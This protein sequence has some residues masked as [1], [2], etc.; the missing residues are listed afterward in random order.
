LYAGLPP[1]SVNLSDLPIVSKPELMAHFDEWVT[2]PA[3]TLAGV[4]A[5][6]ADPGQVG[7]QYLGRCAVWSTSGTTGH[8]GL[9]LHSRTAQALY[10]VLLLLRGWPSTLR[11]RDWARV[12]RRGLREAFV[13]ATGGHFASISVFERIR[14]SYPF[15]APWLC[16]VSVLEPLPEIVQSLNQFQPT[17]LAGYPSALVLLAREQAAGRLAIEPIA[18]A[19]GG[20]TLDPHHQHEI[21]AAFQCPLHDMYGTSEFLYVSFGCRRGWHHLNADWVIFEPV[22]QEYHPVPAG[23]PSH[24]V[25]LT[26][27]ANQI[28]PLI[29]YD[30]GDSVNFKTGPCECGNPLPAM[31]VEGRRDEI[32]RFEA[33]NGRAVAVLPLA[34]ATVLE[35][36]PGVHRFQAIQSAPARVEVRLEPSTGADDAATWE[37]ARLR[38]R[39]YFAGLGLP[40][41]E[42]QRAPEPPQANPLSGKFRQVWSA[43]NG[44]RSV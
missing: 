43:M 37:A 13:V 32:L 12:A 35:E 7:Q 26:N 8:P 6:A 14:R 36:T 24:S 30:L 22:D 42:V 11:A 3:L 15:M 38:L 9:F 28:Q 17:F 18:L 41:V 33:D 27:L 10:Q 31:H 4:K 34:L 40:E 25:L 39:A 5:F 29:R 23:E 44:S 2:D 16:S 19:G 21:E 20:E 1:A